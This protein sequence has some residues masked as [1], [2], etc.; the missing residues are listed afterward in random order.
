MTRDEI[1]HLALECG[2]QLK[3]QP[4]GNMDLH[5]YVY[6]FA[7]TMATFACKEAARTL[8][9]ENEQLKTERNR[10]GVEPRDRTGGYVYADQLLAAHLDQLRAEGWRECAKGQGTSQ[11]CWQLEQAVQA[12]N[13]ACELICDST[14]ITMD[15]KSARSGPD[16]AGTWYEDS[17]V[18]NVVRV[19]AAAIR[20]R[21]K[22]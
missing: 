2:F 12:E 19:L 8:L 1:K 22:Q 5:R 9:I 17:A 18:G 21:R 14:H 10:Q 6:E 3:E 16:G 7:E 13:E 15:G 4:D 11:F 20:A